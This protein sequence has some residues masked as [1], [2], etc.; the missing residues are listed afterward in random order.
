MAT[1]SLEKLIDAHLKRYPEMDILDVYKLLHQGAFGAG[2]S[3]SNRKTAREWLDHEASLI[4]P[5]SG[6]PL[7]ESVH[8]NGAIMRLH[9]RPYLAANGSLP[10]LLDVYVKSA[11]AVKGD[12]AMMQSWW[13]AFSQMILPDA[14]FAGRFDERSVGLVGRTRAAESWAT[15]PHS[16][17]YIALYKPYYRLLTREYANGLLSQQTI[18]SSDI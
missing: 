16:P 11:D 3:I 18:P 10:A 15:A 4:K 5:E 14:P 1:D 2:H 7:L 8:P 6:S 17:R 12:P 13:N 9:L